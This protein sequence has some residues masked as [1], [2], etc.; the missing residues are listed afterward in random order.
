MLP[1]S[2]VGTRSASLPTGR[3]VWT[4]DVTSPLVCSS[5]TETQP[6]TVV[7]PS[8]L[9]MLPTWD[10]TPIVMLLVL[11]VSR[12]GG[13]SFSDVDSRVV[14]GPH[15]AKTAIAVTSPTVRQNSRERR[16]TPVISRAQDLG[17]EIVPSDAG[18]ARGEKGM[19]PASVSRRLGRILAPS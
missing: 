5:F 17:T 19:A 6:P 8:M 4:S 1:S 12:A 10:V 16:V 7:L 13:E 18:H 3:R 9:P 11:P 2:T 15:A 14:D